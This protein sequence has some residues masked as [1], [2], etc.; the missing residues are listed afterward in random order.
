MKN[1]VKFPDRK[2]IEEEA[3]EWLIKLDGD[4]A[5]SDEELA[6]LGKWLDRSPV[7]REQ[8]SILTDTW[9]E[10]NV[11]TELA[12]PLGNT[13]CPADNSFIRDFGQTI[14]R[15]GGAGFVT[16]FVVIGFG[17]FATLRV[18]PDPFLSSN[19]FYATAVG[20][21]QSTTLAD[22]SV[23]LLNTNSQ[24]KVAYDDNS[25]NIYLLQ[26]E[27]HFSVE[28]NVGRPFQVYAGNGL[29]QAVGTA[30]SVYLKDDSFDVTVTEGKVALATID[31]LRA[32]S[33]QRPASPIGSQQLSGSLVIV[34]D[35]FVQ[36]LGTIEAGESA[37]IKSTL[38]ANIPTAITVI[39][40][41]EPRELSRR[42]SWR[43]GVLTFAGDSLEV[44]VNEISRYTAISIEITDPAIRA[45]R[46]GGRFPIGETD[47]MLDALET[48]FGLR[49]TR[50]SHNRVL[51]SAAK[52]E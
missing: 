27:A 26:G 3:A 19:G 24:I 13:K 9:S 8:L 45:T 20:Q 48:N 7:H 15:F 37:T 31:R 14:R 11:L 34:D 25:R 44:V 50:L 29:V 35:S 47:A 22:G 28:T 16:A 33:D 4:K 49:V 36:T 12:V 5:P 10:M 38:D 32:D 42:L 46:I 40:L 17:L 18:Q 23:V 43:E 52:S 39:Q 1:I 6:S 21:Q 30:F 51:V 2:V 41:V